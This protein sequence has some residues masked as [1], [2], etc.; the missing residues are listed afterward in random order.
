MT[1]VEEVM[2]E[3]GEGDLEGGEVDESGEDRGEVLAGGLV[4]FDGVFG[5]P[6]DEGEMPINE[7]KGRKGRVGSTRRGLA[8]AQP[9][10]P[11]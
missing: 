9:A 4:S 2:G 6:V 3:E 7:K 8:T 10:P 1:E 11:F 5:L